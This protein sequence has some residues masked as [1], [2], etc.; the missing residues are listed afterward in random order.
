M[1]T[2]GAAVQIPS[3]ISPMGPWAAGHYRGRRQS[4]RVRHRFALT[5]GLPV[6]TARLSIDRHGNEP[7]RIVRPVGD[8]GT[9]STVRFT[10]R[11]VPIAASELRQY[12]RGDR[13]GAVR[14]SLFFRT[15]AS[16]AFRP[17]RRPGDPHSRVGPSPFSA[18]DWSGVGALNFAAPYM[19]PDPFAHSQITTWRQ[20]Y[21]RRDFNLLLS[22]TCRSSTGKLVIG[23]HS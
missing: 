10:V 6:A 9:T 11:E 7:G 17:S 2:A 1:P 8:S 18:A 13:I 12:F 5:G 14:R 21:P 22:H 15:V 4:N 23:E 20:R 3:T 19:P 16:A